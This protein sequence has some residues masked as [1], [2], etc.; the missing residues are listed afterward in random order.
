VQ[1]EDP[2]PQS[3]STFNGADLDWL[4]ANLDRARTLGIKY[5]SGGEMGPEELDLIFSRWMHETQDKEQNEYIAEALGAVFGAYLV[6]KHGFEWVVVTDEYGT[7][8]AVKHLV[9][10]TIAFPRASIEKRIEDEE[11]EF[12]QRLLLLIL[13]GLKN[14]RAGDEHH[15]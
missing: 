5:G 3:I 15:D 12:F 8:Y 7:E 13:D 4:A 1:T 9:K 10:D 14:S 2:A 6:Q 11:P